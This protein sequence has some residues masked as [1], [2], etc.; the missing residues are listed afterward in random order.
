MSKFSIK[1]IAEMS[2]VSTATVSRVIN[3]KGKYSKKTEKKVLDIIKKVNYQVNF[4]AQS[5]RTNVTKTIG[6]LIPDIINPFFSL[7]VQKLEILLYKN[8]Y[9]TIICN[10]DRDLK[11]EKEYLKTLELK[12]VDALIIISGNSDKGFSFDN[13][14]KH[15]PYIC[16]DREP[17]NFS[18]TIYV[19]SNHLKGSIEAT[20]L[21]IKKGSKN[22]AILISKKLSIS[23]RTRL[24]GF[25]QALKE[26]NIEYNPEKNVI[27]YDYTKEF[28]H[29]ILNFIEKEKIDSVFCTNDNL[30]IKLINLLDKL[31]IKVPK[32]IQIIGFDGIELGNLI[33]PTLSTIKQ[34]IETISEI[35]VMNLID[36][37]NK[38][39]TLGKTIFVPTTL[40]EKKSTL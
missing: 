33:K 26:N 36:L 2:G 38:K 27:W 21:L 31:N 6:I 4:H 19:S 3:K 17:K 16:I 7:L 15:I 18:E 12:N 32:D 8:G 35:A 25:K 13:T 5:L 24:E 40:L 22:P 34:D 10:T 1:D 28:E 9:S 30:A 23:L 11:K 37:I 39:N 20:N 14:S 29:Q